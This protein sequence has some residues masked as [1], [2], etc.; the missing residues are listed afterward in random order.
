MGQG[1]KTPNGYAL[2]SP[3]DGAADASVSIP[4]N[5]RLIEVWAK[6]VDMIVGPSGDTNPLLDSSPTTKGTVVVAGAGAPFEIRVDPSA[7]YAA[8]NGDQ[9]FMG[10]RYT[11][12]HYKPAAAGTGSIVINFYR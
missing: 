9:S 5:T 1:L 6:T 3:A 10:R 8:Y 11:Y 7:N 4:E 12:L 2:A